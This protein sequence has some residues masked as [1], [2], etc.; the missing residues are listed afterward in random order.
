[1][2]S[3]A[4]SR[5]QAIQAMSV[6]GNNADWDQVD[7]RILQEGVIDSPQEAGRQFTLFL[8]QRARMV[9]ASMILACVAALDL[10]TF[11]RTGWGQWLGAADGAGLEGDPDC[12]PRADKLTEI[13]WSK[14]GF[15]TCLKKDEP[16]I[17]GEEKL[18]RLKG[19]GL[20]R[21]GT[22]A[23]HS[24]W[25]D[26]QANGENSVLER[27]RRECGTTYLDF[28]GDVLRSPSGKRCVLYLYWDGGE[29]YW[30]YS[31]LGSGWGARSVSAVLATST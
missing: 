30:D 24:L 25:L 14:V 29:W 4:V 26:Y 11:L 16:S 10:V 21:L 15:E 5:E 13:D 31:Y 2:S 22:K 19:K 23:F 27:L 8:C 17:T 20:L 12:D 7:S 9:L 28:F 3:Q 18:K 1:M 6:L